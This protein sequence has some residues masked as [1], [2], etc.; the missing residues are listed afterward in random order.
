MKRAGGS[1]LSTHDPR[2]VLGLG[3]ATAVD[4][5]EIIW[6]KPSQRVDRL[7]DLQVNRYHTVVEGKGVISR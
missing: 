2:E 6:P 4:W 3:K 7:T 5:A 1:Y